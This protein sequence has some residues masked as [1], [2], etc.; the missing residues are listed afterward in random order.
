VRAK[1]PAL[2]D[3]ARKAK[4][5]GEPLVVYT[6][7]HGRGIIGAIEDALR[8]ADETLRIERYTGMQSLDAR[9]ATVEKFKKGEI[10]VLIGSQPICTGV[11]GLQRVCSKMF[12]MLLPMTHGEWLQLRGRLARKGQREGKV[13][14]ILVPFATLRGGPTEDSSDWQ[15][16]SK[17]GRIADAAVDG[18]LPMDYRAAW[19]GDRGERVHTEVEAQLKRFLERLDEDG[20]YLK[21]R[22]RAAP[23]PIATGG[24]AA[25][26]AGAGAAEESG[27]VEGAGAMEVEADAGARAKRAR[28]DGDGDGDGEG[29]GRRKRARSMPE[30][31]TMAWQERMGDLQDD[32][33]E[34]KRLFLDRDNCSSAAANTVVNKFFSWCRDHRLERSRDAAR[35]W[36]GTQLAG[37]DEL[38]ASVERMQQQARHFVLYSFWQGMNKHRRIGRSVPDDEIRDMVAKELCELWVRRLDALRDILTCGDGACVD[39]CDQGAIRA[40]GARLTNKERSIM[41]EWD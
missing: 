21:A 15:R 3:V 19:R 7:Y 25:A 14:E 30:E 10:D 23:L 9:A 26:V 20:A 4:S 41:E 34:A 27:D 22:P 2:V 37:D 28:E 33:R 18:D 31:R 11:D 13:V 12:V 35:E 40:L 8:G 1:L 36:L 6:H 39:F 16:I 32:F 5:E 29:E 24:G 17:K 38:R